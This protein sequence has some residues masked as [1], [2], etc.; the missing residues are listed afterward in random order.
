MPQQI[1]LATPI[2]LSQKRYFSAQTMAIS[3]GIFTVFGGVLAGGMVWSLKS[4]SAGFTQTMANQAREIESLQAAIQRIKASA[5]PADAGLGQELQN[6]RKAVSQ[7]QQLLSALKEGMLVPGEG[8]SDRLLWV[9]R[10]IPQ[11][12]WVTQVKA[13]QTRLEVN[14]FT[15]EP[16]ALN[17]W[18]DR[19]ADSPLMRGLKLA[20]VKVEN[21]VAPATATAPAITP[22]ANAGDPVAAS[23]ARPVWGFS[24]VNLMPTP[25]QAVEANSAVSSGAK[26]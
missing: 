26:P 19:L 25:A 6:K 10:S 9:A 18:V 13:D 7:K 15:L 11:P 1:N 24:M 23:S 2:L 21:T 12:V 16:A 22:V 14:G 3:L 8:H 17:A 5:A 4:S 20:S